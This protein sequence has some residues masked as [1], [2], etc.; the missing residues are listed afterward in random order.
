MRDVGPSPAIPLADFHC[1]AI[2]FPIRVQP[3][4][5]E[6]IGGQ[7]SLLT[8]GKSEFLKASEYILAEHG[9]QNVLDLTGAESKLCL[10]I[11]LPGQQVIKDQHFGEDGCG[12]GAGEWGFVVEV[13]LFA[14]QTA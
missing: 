11:R 6:L 13:I 4:V 2:I 3:E 14:A 12:L 10:T 8:C 5:P 9:G 1:L 7:A